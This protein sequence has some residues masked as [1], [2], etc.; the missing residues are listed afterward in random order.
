MI[1]IRLE[2]DTLLKSKDLVG[3]QATPTVLTNS[4]KW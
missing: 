3:Y 2:R 4:F 1:T